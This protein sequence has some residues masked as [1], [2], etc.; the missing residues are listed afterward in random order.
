MSTIGDVPLKREGTT[1]RFRIKLVLVVIVS[2]AIGLAA[3]TYQVGE[4]SWVPA[5]HDKIKQ[6]LGI[7]PDFDPATFSGFSSQRYEFKTDW[8]FPR[9][10]VYQLASLDNQ[11]FAIDRH[12]GNL[13]GLSSGNKP[14]IVLKSQLFKMLS[15]EKSNKTDELPLVMDIHGAFGNLYFS[16]AQLESKSCER[17]HLYVASLKGNSLGKVDELFKTP[18]ISDHKNAQMWGGRMTNSQSSLFLGIGEQRYDRSGFPKPG[19]GF[20]KLQLDVNSVFGSVL[21]FKNESQGYTVFSRGH[22]NAQGIFYNQENG[23]LLESEHGPFGGDEIN[24]L[25]RGGNYGW[26]FATFGKPYP[27]KYPSGKAEIGDSMNPSIGVDKALAAFNGISGSQAG[28]ELPLFSWS[29]GMG[30]GNLVE[31]SSKSSLLEWRGNIFI[32]LMGEGS[33]HR[34]ILDNGKVVNDETI[35]FG[36]RVR[37]FIVTDSGF[38][39]ASTD[40]GEFVRL[41]TYSSTPG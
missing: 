24:L 11:F 12:F 4:R 21:E 35:Q 2:F 14:T 38:I 18:C 32:A 28:Y 10:G 3:S 36:K 17:L 20:K 25:S 6:L 19:A 37:D 5:A 34:L 7:V 15:I 13:Y 1:L 30:P 16:I 26:P 27:T 41:S 31:I 23:Q 29:P 33:F 40:N 9:R 8:R 39:Y 22:R